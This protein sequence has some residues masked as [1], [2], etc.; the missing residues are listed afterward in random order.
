MIIDKIKKT[1][2]RY[3]MI[4]SGDGVV[5]GLSGGP[6]S[7]C[8]FHVL[9]TLKEELGVRSIYAVHINHGL[10]GA[11]SDG[12]EAYARELAES[13]GAEFISYN[14]DVNKIAR[15]M[16]VSTEEAGRHMR[17]CAF[18]RVRNEKKAQRIAVAHNMNDQAETILMRIM[19]GTG[20]KG[21]AGIEHVRRDGV[22]IR[23]V[24]D[25]SRSEIE[26]YCEENSLK[27]RIDSTNG[28]PLYT[29]N[30]I[31][32]ELLPMMAQTFNPNITAALIRLGRQAAE[33]EDFI[34]REAEAYVDGEEILSNSQSA[35]GDSDSGDRMEGTYSGR[36]S[37]QEQSL[38]LKG[39]SAL[40]PAVAKRA[41]RICAHR[42]GLEQN[43]SAVHLDEIATLAASGTEAKEL[44]IADG[45]YVR[46]SYG[47]LWFLQRDT[48]GARIGT[49]VPV[50]YETLLQSGEAG[51]CAGGRLIHMR[52]DEVQA[53]DPQRQADGRFV[54]AVRED[55]MSAANTGRIGQGFDDPVCICVDFDKLM[56]LGQAVFR[57]KRQG[58][59]IRPIGMQ[60]SKKLQDFFI[61]R[62]IPRHLRG[63]MIILECGG[64]IISA[65]K[66]TAAECALSGET[67]RILTIEY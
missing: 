12:D 31:R 62:K 65:G 24:L 67:Q 36:W 52:L 42:A 46:L 45:Y 40:H 55:R 10:R 17:Y 66:E 59:R 48:G 43:M 34:Y 4:S 14:Y 49:P 35:S 54:G 6:D 51:V 9:C 63:T 20:I 64:R 32:L 53:G 25:I 2:N 5:V 44:D 13:C 57:N 23:P 28:Q 7:V 22:L 58:D 33:D 21:L 61:D 15:D 30:K 56:A 3:D 11:E 37:G 27:P 47:K 50:P 26:E 16:G 18:E 60:G 41:V 8:L 39:F 1:I 29:R 38:A 19:R